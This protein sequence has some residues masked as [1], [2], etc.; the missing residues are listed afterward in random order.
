MKA[1][2]V[3]L[4]IFM[5]SDCSSC[6]PDDQEGECIPN[7]FK[8][9]F[10]DYSVGVFNEEYP[11]ECY[12]GP[13]AK[14]DVWVTD[15]ECV[16]G[17]HCLK[18]NM[19]T[20]SSDPYY[21][22]YVRADTGCYD[23]YPV[24]YSQFYIKYLYSDGRV[25]VSF[26]AGSHFGINISN[27]YGVQAGGGAPEYDGQFVEPGYINPGVWY[28]I[29]MRINYPEQRKL[30][31][32]VYQGDSITLVTG[33]TGLSEAPTYPI[34]DVPKSVVHFKYYSVYLYEHLESDLD[35]FSFFIDDFVIS[36]DPSVLK[37]GFQ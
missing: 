15:R 22:A 16:A 26:N 1:V 3:I 37:A 13:A 18:V 23:S 35:N 11:W 6:V 36:D 25:L 29:E 12:A 8:D 34:D 32:K 14:L 4:L 7:Y 30:N 2:G 17:N 10:E 24:I 28:R 20:A 19:F 27:Q 33:S 5:I 9:G 31:L 21:N